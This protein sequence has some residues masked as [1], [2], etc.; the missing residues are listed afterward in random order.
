MHCAICKAE[1]NN[2]SRQ[3]PNPGLPCDST[4]FISSHN[5]GCCRHFQRRHDP[6]RIRADLV[7]AAQVKPGRGRR[8]SLHLIRERHDE[9]GRNSRRHPS[10]RLLLPLP[11]RVP[12]HRSRPPMV[13]KDR[14]PVAA[15]QQWGELLSEPQLSHQGLSQTGR[16]GQDR[17]VLTIA[18]A[19][20]RLS[21]PTRHDAGVRPHAAS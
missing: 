15:D 20:G 17:S 14:W 2:V 1:Y 11:R 9:R 16:T 18:L 13:S 3:Y 12:P 19:A 7:A 10:L 8:L 21:P 6:I 4:L 5:A